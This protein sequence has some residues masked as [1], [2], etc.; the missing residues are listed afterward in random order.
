[1]IIPSTA[2]P[3]SARNDGTRSFALNPDIA[4]I[5]KNFGSNNWEEVEIFLSNQI[6]L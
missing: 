5:I 3:N 2:N 4:N 6:T 1:M